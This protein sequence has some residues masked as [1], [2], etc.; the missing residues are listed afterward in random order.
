MTYF[1]RNSGDYEFIPWTS[2]LDE[3]M[4]KYDMRSP[5]RSQ[6]IHR[7][8]TEFIFG[9]A[10]SR[11]FAFAVRET[12]LRDKLATW[13]YVLDRE[14]TRTD[15][16]TL[17]IPEPKHRN[18]QSDFDMFSQDFSDDYWSYVRHMLS[19]NDELFI[20]DKAASYFWANLTYYLYRFLSIGHS[21]KIEMAD[22]LER[23]IDEEERAF[24]IS[25]G[26]LVEDKKGK[27]QDDDYY[28]DAGFYRGDRR[29]D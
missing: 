11:Q 26:L 7:I 17:F 24:L 3:K 20:N 29:Y 22:K 18:K 13:M 28:R 27:R 19:W 21:L 9:R 23:E 25:E 15:L 16:P 8:V 6:I 12:E 2:W 5:T 10:K 14:F 4:N 1:S